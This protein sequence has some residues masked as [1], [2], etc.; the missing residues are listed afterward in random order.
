MQFC[1]GTFF[2]TF[3]QLLLPGT[4]LHTGLPTFLGTF[5]QCSW[6]MVLHRCLGTFLA[7]FLSTS[8][9]WWPYTKGVC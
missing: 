3:L 1:D 5:S 7:T 9:Q 6:G 2:G 8:T 4:L